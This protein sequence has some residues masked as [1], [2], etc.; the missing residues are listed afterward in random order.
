MPV[1]PDGGE[2]GAPAGT[3]GSGGNSGV[4]GEGGSGGSCTVELLSNPGFDATPAW[5]ESAAPSGSMLVDSASE[6]AIELGEAFDAQS[7]PNVLWL[8]GV[9]NDTQLASLSVTIPAQTTEVRVTGYVIIA[10]ELESA[11]NDDV[12]YVGFIDG[13][14]TLPIVEWDALDANEQWTF[15]SAPFD[16][17]GLAGRTLSFGVGAT[18]D[19]TENTNFFFDSLSLTVCR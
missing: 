2:A 3:G 15:F 14:T 6:I 17:S 9:E 16:A 18:T 19:G 11:T 7:P 10:T 8:G 4:G 1:D 5:T 13:G 12:A